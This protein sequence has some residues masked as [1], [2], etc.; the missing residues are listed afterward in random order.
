M[1]YGLSYVI[2]KLLQN[3]LFDYYLYNSQIITSYNQVQNS[4]VQFKSFSV[5][6]C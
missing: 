6:K 4:I 5:D 1:D 2:G 3:D